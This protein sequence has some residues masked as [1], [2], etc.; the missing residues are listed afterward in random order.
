MD[1]ASIKHAAGKRPLLTV[2]HGREFELQ[3]RRLSIRDMSAID[4]ET[5]RYVLVGEGDAKQVHSVP[6]GAA[7]MSRY[8]DEIK[9][10]SG[11]KVRHLV[12]EAL[13]GVDPD[14][15]VTF[16]REALE[17]LVDTH[18]VIMALLVRELQTAALLHR[19]AQDT[20]EKN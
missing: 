17:T 7:R 4:A 5:T 14:E 12:A 16:S 8:L 20:A 13:P 6:D 10:W 2:K 1:F 11:V 3:V 9:G 19:Q 18:P 15:D